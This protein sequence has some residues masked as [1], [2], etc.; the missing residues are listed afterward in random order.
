MT[1]LSGCLAV[2]NF[3]TLC[4]TA[5]IAC[6]QRKTMIITQQVPHDET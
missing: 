4:K 1:E 2:F 5:L 3:S 6:S